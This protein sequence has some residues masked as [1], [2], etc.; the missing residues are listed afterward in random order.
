MPVNAIALTWP[1]SAIHGWGVFGTNL[2]REVLHR[3]GIKPI[4]LFPMQEDF[5]APDDRPLFQPLIDEQRQ[6]EAQLAEVQGN[7][8]LGG[9]HVLHSLGNDLVEPAA[10]ARFRGEPNVGFTFFE[11]MTFAPDVV[12]RN[13]HFQIMMAGSTWNAEILR[14]LGFPRV[15]C[16]FQGVDT[17][18]FSPS[19]KTGRF[20]DR[21]VVFSGGKL[22]LRKGQDLVV[23]AFKRFHER[24]PDSLLVTVWLNPWPAIM[25]DLAASPHVTTLPDINTP[26]PNCINDWVRDQGV[27]E[28]AHIDLSPTFNADMPVLLREC[29]AALFPNR[30]EGG[31][32]LV[33]MEAMAA[34]LP[35]VLS[36]NSGHLD[37]TGAD[38]SANH[39]CY[40]LTR[41]SPV[42][43]GPT[44]SEH[45]R[46]SD[47]DEIVE[48][49]EAIYQDRST[50]KSR[51][52]GAHDFM[53]DWSWR[54][55]IDRLL[56]EL[57]RL[58]P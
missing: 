33:A 23:A 38:L 30:C 54:N 52:D 2:L 10:S 7:I 12:A 11:N 20:G 22:E 48:T 40:P 57:G 35:C 15:G 39:R 18:A 49:L 13:A 21:F 6:I 56:S 8:T 42:P 31:T 37:L 24:H 29:D 26:F 34:G 46:E 5:I 53:Q 41:Q 44:G 51:G 4:T 25:Q 28:G 58:T 3:G 36:A 45:W 1:P 55:Q 27:P 16:V 14:D 9:V 50:A 19:P 17:D 32:N 47:I 43:F